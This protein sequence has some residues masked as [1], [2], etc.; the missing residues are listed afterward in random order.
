MGDVLSFPLMWAGLLLAGAVL[1]SGCSA[2]RVTLLPDQSGD[3]GSVHVFNA[4]GEQRI[5]RAFESIVVDGASAPSAPR[6]VERKAF[7]K[8]HRA[9]IDAQPTS[10][11]TFL[12]HFLFDSM[13]LTPESKKLLP[14]V[15]EVVRQRRPTEVTVFG[16]A[17]AAGTPEYNLALSAS[18]AQAVA[19]MLKQIDPD[20]PIEVRYFGDMVL[21]VPTPPGVAEPRNRRAEIVVL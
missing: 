19:R 11:R 17:D 7:E 8:Q 2:T 9:L 4:Q 6:A 13:E 16:Y 1:L 5:D 21:L 10:P 14:A 3:V 20:L 12:L 18:R 15:L